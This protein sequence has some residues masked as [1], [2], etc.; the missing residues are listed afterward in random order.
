MAPRRVLAWAWLAALVWAG[1]WL[2]LRLPGARLDTD[3]SGLAPWAAPEPAV[4]AA[5]SAQRSRVERSALV[6][7]GAPTAR[8]AAQGADACA[9]VLGRAP[10]VAVRSRLPRGAGTGFLDFYGPRSGLLLSREDARSLR[11]GGEDLLRR[12][13]AAPFLPAWEDGGLGFARD[14]FGL[15]G[16]WLLETSARLGRLAPEAGRLTLR[17]G[18][19]AW[20]A[21]TVHLAS[22]GAA[23]ALG[24]DW[25]AAAA[26]ARGA[27]ARVLLRAG[28]PFHEAAAAA[29]ARR[30]SGMVGALSTALLALLLVPVFGSPRT[31]F[32]ALLPALVGCVFGATAVLLCWSRVH[33]V[34]LVFGSTV[35]GVADDYGLYFLCGLYDGVWDPVRR[36]RES[37]AP[38]ALAAATSVAGYAALAF[39]P[40]PALRQVAVFAG[41]GLSLDF[42]GVLLWYPRLS[43]RLGP[44]S[45]GRVAAAGILAR[46][47]PR[48]VRSVARGALVLGLVAGVWGCLRLGA[49]DDVRLLY[50]HDAAL[51]REEARLRGLVGTP[52]SSSFFAVWGPSPETVLEREEAL[53]AALDRAGAPGSTAV[54]VFVPSL[55][56]QAE[57]RA[58]VEKA[59][60]GRAALARRLARALGAPSL[61]R[62][63]ARALDR[64]G[65]RLD[66]ES[67]LADPVSAPWRGLW[68]RGPGYGWASVVAPGPGLTPSRLAGL[69]PALARLAGVAYVDPVG[70]ATD[71]MRG[72]RWRLAW[73]L[74]AGTLLVGAVL[75][76]SLGSRA[77]GALLPFAYGGLAGLGALGWS[78]QPLNLFSLLALLLLLGTAVDFGIYTQASGRS[79]SSFVAVPVAALVNVAA[80]GVLAFSGTP[81]LRGFGL[82]LSVGILAAWAC[83]AA[84]APG[85]PG[86]RT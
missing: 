55:R 38:L 49:D 13:E 52:G 68:L 2:A 31:A 51:D 35:V 34:A 63:L 14:P 75:A 15:F 9:A 48:W 27:G 60:F 82:V 20:V 85:R 71:L 25:P 57:S 16:D 5:E 53:R 23:Q 32:L 42:A 12:A 40:I 19:M 28:F 8:E 84:L 30:E 83:A 37:A 76:V 70:S 80:V 79:L 44:L 46:G 56:R 65:P 45:P 24:A 17:S 64:P 86:A 67:W 43:A 29:Q 47:R 69:G 50:A 73:V 7:V 4:R 62:R 39:L 1:L 10:G 78:G 21:V 59:L 3:I 22:G 66:P 26:A 54:S 58:A 33:A 77:W 6:L 11:S 61:A 41:V 36:L 81:A 74:A 18:G 72:L